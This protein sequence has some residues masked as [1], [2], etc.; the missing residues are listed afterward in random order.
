[1]DHS[2]TPPQDLV[3]ACLQ[4]DDESAWAEFI[5]RFQPLIAGI[6]LRVARQWGEAHPQVIDDLV[7]E[8]Y[9]KL[10]AE[11]LRL[12]ENFKS[13]HP[14]SIYGFIK[15]FA[16]NLAHD[17]FKASH[18]QKRGGA[19]DTASMDADPVVQQRAARIVP[20]IAILERKLLLEQVSACLDTVASGPHAKRDCRIF[21]LYYRAGVSASAI[22]T[23]PT[24]GLSTKGVESTISRL[25]R[26][27]R[28]QL[29]LPRKQQ[30]TSK[31]KE[32][33][34]TSPAESF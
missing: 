30:G 4:G 20:E 7:Q 22:A 13:E 29:A 15:V 31:N 34:G 1:V 24:I 28:R 21:W 12:F 9:L 2:K 17:H 8:T 14:D 19:V 5:R 18:A 33:E 23:L 16:A 26:A 11:R 6:A 27:L 3:L 10:C 25:T 32:A